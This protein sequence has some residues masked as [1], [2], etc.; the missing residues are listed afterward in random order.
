MDQK[1]H[2]ENNIAS[3]YILRAFREGVATAGR[4]NSWLSIG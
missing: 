3:H 4:L 2:I 1:E